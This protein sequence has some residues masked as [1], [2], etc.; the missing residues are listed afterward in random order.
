MPE[1]LTRTLGG[2]LRS[3][4]IHETSSLSAET[5]YGPSAAPYSTMK[6][7]VFDNSGANCVNFCI[8]NGYNWAGVEIGVD[9]CMLTSLYPT[10]RSDPF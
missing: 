6:G 1:T 4:P 5:L 3:T 7:A 8:G 10:Q 9:C 2:I